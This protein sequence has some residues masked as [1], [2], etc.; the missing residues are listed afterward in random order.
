MVCHIV[1]SGCFLVV[2]NGKVMLLI[3]TTTATRY[4]AHNVHV[5]FW[6]GDCLGGTKNG[7]DDQSL[8]FLL[9]LMLSLLLLFKNEQNE[10]LVI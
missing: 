6:L 3:P 1:A 8:F 7:L 4:C 5:R 9:L 2:V 10:Q